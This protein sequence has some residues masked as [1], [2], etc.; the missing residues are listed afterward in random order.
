VL[1]VITFVVARSSTA[2]PGSPAG[3]LSSSEATTTRSA[4]AQLLAQAEQRHP[5]YTCSV[6]GPTNGQCTK[7]GSLPIH[8]LFLIETSNGVSSP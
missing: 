5:G 1:P 3:M 4:V 7:P 8:L 6:T 2:T